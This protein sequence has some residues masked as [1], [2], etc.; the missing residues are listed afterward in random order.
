[1]FIIVFVFLSPFSMILL[2]AQSAGAV[3]YAD[4][5]SAKG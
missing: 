3:E 4:S 2:T 1:M 5:Q